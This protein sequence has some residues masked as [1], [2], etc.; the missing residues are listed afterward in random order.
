M[1]ART[2]AESGVTLV[3][4]IIYMSVGVMLLV[5][6][7]Q[8]FVTGWQSDAATRDRDRATAEAQLAASV[9]QTSIR[10][11]S[12][13]FI[14]GNLMRATVAVGTDD[15]ECRAWLLTDDDR[16]LQTSQPGLIPV[17]G[18][19]PDWTEIATGV[20]GTLN[21]DAPFAMDGAAATMVRLG[22]TVTHGDA[23][24]PIAGGAAT[25]AHGEG[26]PSC[27]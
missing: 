22:F 14:V 16:L 24:I 10:S 2:A 20:A 26:A 5:G 6:V 25:Q 13:V 11:A 3:E 8:I 7:G 21:S 23:V 12:D 18:D 27:W 4:L 19:D 17:P 15:W 9:M 1:T